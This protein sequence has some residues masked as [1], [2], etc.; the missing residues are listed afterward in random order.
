M[1]KKMVVVPFEMVQQMLEPSENV[2]EERKMQE[3]LTNKELNKRFPDDFGPKEERMATVINR[4]IGRTI[5]KQEPLNNYL[6]DSLD[7]IPG[8]QEQEDNVSKQSLVTLDTPNLQGTTQKKKKKT[9]TKTSLK[10]SPVKVFKFV[11]KHSDIKQRLLDANKITV[12]GA[13]K[14]KTGNNL[15]DSNIDLILE[16]AEN[17]KGK[18]PKGT[19]SIFD[20][21]R[22]NEPN[23]FPS[24]SKQTGKGWKIF[25]RGF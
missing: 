17:L 9:P 6:N 15:K 21:L 5:V 20:W 23:Y 14:Y 2:T 18:K 22:N 25:F 12:D 11:G 4:P 10:T 3:A 16:Y 24:I 13:I 7:I 1:V 8:I 19:D